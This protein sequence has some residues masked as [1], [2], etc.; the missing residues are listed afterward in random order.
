MT[1]PTVGDAAKEELDRRRQFWTKE[2]LDRRRDFLDKKNCDLEIIGQ[3]K[4]EELV[5]LCLI[6]EGLLAG[7]LPLKKHKAEP[8]AQQ[9]QGLDPMTVMLQMMQQMRADADRREREIEA[10]KHDAI[11]QTERREREIEAAKHDAIEQAERREERYAKQLQSQ[12]EMF[13]RMQ[14]AKTVEDRAAREDRKAK[15]GTKESRIKTFGELLKKVLFNMPQKITEIPVYLDTVDRIFSEYNVK[16]DIKINLLNPYLS[17]AARKLVVTLPQQDMADYVSFKA[18]LLR[19]FALT[20]NK[21]RDLFWQADK[22]AD[23]TY[24]QYA[25]RLKAL[26]NYYLNSRNVSDFDKMKTLIISD[27][28]KLGLPQYILQDVNKKELDAFLD[29]HEL[30]VMSDRCVM[31][32]DEL[33]ACGNSFGNNGVKHPFVK[34]KSSGRCFSCG[35]TDNYANNVNCLNYK[36]PVG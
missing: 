34:K 16:D 33:K 23:E 32:N 36:M 28:M 29:P 3:L 26:L 11:E 9:I 6:A 7:T 4:G 18:A 27:K 13:A 30:G 2:N 14:D 17:V 15:D 22:K 5:Q 21:Y 35:S 10:A 31:N 24:T 1:E 20:P 8:A 19:E 25:T 12:M